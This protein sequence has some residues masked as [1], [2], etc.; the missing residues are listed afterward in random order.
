MKADLNEEELRGLRS[1][2]FYDR[3][4]EVREAVRPMVEL[5]A[6]LELGKHPTKAAA[7]SDDGLGLTRSRH[8]IRHR[9]GIRVGR[10]SQMGQTSI[11]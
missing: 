2:R 5:V 7:W 1:R 10:S 9:G 4:H 3:D 6:A 8:E 11:R